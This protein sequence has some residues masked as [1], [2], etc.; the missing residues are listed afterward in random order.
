MQK[1]TRLG[2]FYTTHADYILKDLISVLPD[3]AELIEPFCGQRDLLI[4]SHSYELYDI[5]P[6]IP[7]CI[8]RDTLTNP[9]DYTGKWVV[10]NP[11]FLARN[12]STDKKIF[13]LWKVS[14]LYKAAVLSML[15]CAGGVLILPLNFFCDDDD[16]TRKK[17]FAHFRIVR[18]KVF[19]EQIFDDTPYTCCAFSFVRGSS[20][21]IP[22]QFLPSGEEAEFKVSESGGWRIGSEFWDLL[23][24]YS[25]HK[26]SRLAKGG[27]PNSQ[28]FL[29]AIDTGSLSGRIGLSINPDLHYGEKNERTFAS[30]V[31]DKDYTLAEQ[32]VICQEF[33][34]VLEKSRAEFRSMFL[35]SFRNSSKSYARKRM[36]FEDAYRLMNYVIKKILWPNL[37]S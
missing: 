36:G 35:T 7:S 20:T 28:I 31:L 19:E 32:E 12:K 18:L 22:V 29:R 6:K 1:K 3:D 37:N 5:D 16:S 34:R 2:Q 4:T 27:I 17:F 9:P 11:P 23:R 25:R 10:T 33:N 24:P 30:I 21:S 13:D 26:I 8:R 14:D 15:G